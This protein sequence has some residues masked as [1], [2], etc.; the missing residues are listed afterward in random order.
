VAGEVELHHRLVELFSYIDQE[1]ADLAA[2]VASIPATLLTQ[3]PAPGRWSI[4]EVLEHLVITERRTTSLLGQLITDAVAKGLPPETDTRPI[5]A[6]IDTRRVTDRSRRLVTADS[7]VPPGQLRPEEAL[8][9]LDTAR[10]ELKHTVSAGSG[11]ALGTIVHPHRDFGP[12]N[13]YEWVAFAGAHMARHNE[14]IREIARQL[15]PR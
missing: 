8:F 11:Y 5:L 2:T 3:S 9:A 14:Q 12:M 4:V 6:V 10:R 7:L 1:H 15:S 13:L